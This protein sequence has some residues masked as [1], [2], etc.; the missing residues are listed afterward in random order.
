MTN[1]RQMNTEENKQH[2]GPDAEDHNLPLDENHS[3]GADV[4][5]VEQP[6]AEH[7]P[8]DPEA[9]ADSETDIA[10]ALAEEK[11]RYL[12]LYSEFDN[13]RKRTSR[14]KIELMQTAGK[15][16]IVSMLGVIDDLERALKLT[17]NADESV[18]SS[19]EGF[20]LIY[21]KMMG[22]LEARGL[23]AIES[24]G[25][26]FDVEFQEA[27]TRFPAPS[28]ELKGKVLDEVEK[29]YTLNGHVIRFAKVVVG[30]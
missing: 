14:E 26:P 29:G 13:F 9:P 28:E 24:V 7:F 23:K 5:S 15:D 27:I 22:T 4:N 16:I 25:K 30:E 17:A 19:L 12:R 11:D 20:E 8:V 18:K 21:K 2:N 6:E 3:E 10:A 1:G